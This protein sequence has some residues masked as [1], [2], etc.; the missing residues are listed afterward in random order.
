VRKG[1]VLDEQTH[2]Q[3]AVTKLLA[4]GDLLMFHDTLYKYPEMTNEDYISIRDS[5]DLDEFGKYL[6]HS[7]LTAN[8]TAG[9][10]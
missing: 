6:L 5:P 9:T 10:S 8:L 7:S 2:F 1:Q 3:V 4:P